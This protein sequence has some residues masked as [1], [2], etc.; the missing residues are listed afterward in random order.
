MVIDIHAH[1]WGSDISGCKRKLLKAIDV[2]GID[3]VYVSGLQ[4][5]WSGEAEIDYLT[6]A[7]WD[8]MRE[9]P[10]RRCGLCQSQKRK[11][12]GCDPLRC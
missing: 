3:R 7:V 12:Y 5:L 6:D 4:N 9:E 8:F 2:Y 10:D 1:I 11:R